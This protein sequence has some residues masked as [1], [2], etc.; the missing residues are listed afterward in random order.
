M[1]M[2]FRIFRVINEARSS[3]DASWTPGENEARLLTSNS[4]LVNL[5]FLAL[6]GEPLTMGRLISRRVAR[7]SSL[8]ESP[9]MSISFGSVSFLTLCF[10]EL[11]SFGEQFGE[12][13]DD[14]E[15]EVIEE[16]GETALLSELFCWPSSAKF[17]LSESGLA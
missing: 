8:S 5:G 10:N 4:S 1:P 16:F 3:L 9:P 6:G 12:T 15:E 17:G 2:S 11:N 13:D 14:D 7:S